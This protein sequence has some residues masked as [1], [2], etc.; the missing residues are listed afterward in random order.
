MIEYLKD[1]SVKICYIIY[2]S[3]PILLR[4]VCLFILFNHDVILYL[5]I[6][7]LLLSFV[8]LYNYRF[9]CLIIDL[10]IYIYIYIYIYI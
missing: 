2:F 4:Y 3:Y 5:Y 1:S 8:Y 7:A 6:F 9:I 10:N